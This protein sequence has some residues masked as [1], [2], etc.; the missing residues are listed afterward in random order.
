MTA[1]VARTTAAAS[2]TRTTPTTA[3][4]ARTGSTAAASVAGPTRLTG[5]ARR[6]RL[7]LCRHAGR[8]PA[9]HECVDALQAQVAALGV[10]ELDRAMAAAAGENGNQDN[11]DRRAGD[12]PKEPS[13]RFTLLLFLGGFGLQI[14]RVSTPT[15]AARGIDRR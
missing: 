9:Q 10:V 12:D 2:T 3:A 13:H 14:S 5:R 11:E 15:C 1:T 6:R 4:T 7:L 8:P